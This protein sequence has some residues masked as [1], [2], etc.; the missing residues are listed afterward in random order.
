MI[1]G[2]NAILFQAAAVKVTD[3]KVLSGDGIIP[4]TISSLLE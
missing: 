4:S 2:R 3:I 1:Q